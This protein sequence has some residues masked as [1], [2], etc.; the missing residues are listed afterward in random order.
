MPTSA[1]KK[2]RELFFWRD[3]QAHDADL[4]NPILDDGDHGKAEG[5]SRKVAK[6]LG[7]SDADIEALYAK[8]KQEKAMNIRVKGRIRTKQDDDLEP[9]DGET[10]EDFMDRCTGDEG[11]DSDTCQMIWDDRAAKGIVHKT[12]AGDVS[13]MEFVLSD[14]TP[15]RMDDIIMSDGW[16]L[17]N[18][19]KNPIALFNHNPNFIVGKWTGVKIADKALRGK[20]ELAP[21][22]T[23]D[24][25]D[26]IRKLIE[27]GILKAVSVG[28]RSARCQGARHQESVQRY[29]ISQAGTGRD[30]ARLGPGK[31]QRAGGCQI[32][33]SFPL[34]HRSRVRR[35]WQTTRDQAARVHRRA[36]RKQTKW[37][38][39][40]YV[41]GSTHHRRRKASGGKEGQAICIARRDRRDERLRRSGRGDQQ[42]ER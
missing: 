28:F 36:S 31:P 10:Y 29:A 14:E 11:E 7:L 16:D 1:P 39:H 8:P 37:K 17:A 24:R 4:H 26:E 32:T 6:R 23:S 12:H 20:L 38:G 18:F 21:A 9:E 41:V 22:G 33:R 19:K 35:A 5:V 42:G 15:D 27:A 25:I 13:G 3:H 2:P 30:V 40:D 34:D